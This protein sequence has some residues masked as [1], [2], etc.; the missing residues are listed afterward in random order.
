MNHDEILNLLGALLDGELNEDQ[1]KLIEDH[2]KDCS[3][4]QKELESLKKLDLL[5][6][7]YFSS[8]PD[9]QY[10]KTFAGRVSKEITSK[11]NPARSKETKKMFKDS[12][13]E[14]DGRYGLR[15]TVFPL[16]VLAHAAI[17]LI[18][19]VYPLMNP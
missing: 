8:S 17:V 14:G 2:L 4:C 18:M 6:K 13:I 5:S 15:A 3:A 7:D 12:F 10:W 1:S 9:D 19:L 16:S 11:K